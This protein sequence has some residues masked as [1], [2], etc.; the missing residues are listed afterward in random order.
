MLIH[1]SNYQPRVFGCPR[2]DGWRH[3]IA[4]FDSPVQNYCLTYVNSFKTV[5]ALDDFLEN[6]SHSSSMTVN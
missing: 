5:K 6:I 3:F 4:V 2:F 1:G